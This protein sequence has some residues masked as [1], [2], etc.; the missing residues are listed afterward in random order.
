MA[1]NPGENAELDEVS[2]A[3]ADEESKGAMR[4]PVSGMDAAMSAGATLLETAQS[5]RARM[6]RRG[7]T[8]ELPAY[9]MV[10]SSWFMAFGLQIG[11]QHHLQ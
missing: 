8:R 4:S 3:A 11:K 5:L 1:Q 2:G 9:L 6:V 10:Q 7:V